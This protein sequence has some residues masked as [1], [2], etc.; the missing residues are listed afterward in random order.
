MP[1]AQQL[2]QRAAAQA[3]GAARVQFALG[4]VSAKAEDWAVAAAAYEAA[5]AAEAEPLQR[6]R[7]LLGLGVSRSSMA[8]VAP[9]T[10]ARPPT[11][12]S[13]LSCPSLAGL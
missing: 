6:G 8:R 4:Q 5:A 12:A 11:H 10:S 1:E 7:A 2:L 9:P 3:P 13:R